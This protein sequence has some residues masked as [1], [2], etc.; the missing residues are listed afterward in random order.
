RQDVPDSD[1]LLDAAME[2]WPHILRAYRQFEERRPI[3]L[4]DIQERGVYVYPYP[5]FKAEV[6]ERSQ[7]SLQEQYE[8]AARD[9]KGV[10]VVRDNDQRRLVSFSLDLGQGGTDPGSAAS[11]P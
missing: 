3:V 8:K 1:Y 10:G 6:S 2:N 7:L 5:E 9:N 11:R 4:D